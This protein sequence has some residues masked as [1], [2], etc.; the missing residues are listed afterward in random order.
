VVAN[1]VDP[2]S[3]TLDGRRKFRQAADFFEK[4]IDLFI[5]KEKKL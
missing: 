5:F 2:F 4:Q 3:G 1:E